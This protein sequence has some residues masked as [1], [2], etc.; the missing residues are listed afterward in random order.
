MALDPSERLC[1]VVLHDDR[2]SQDDVL[3]STDILPEGKI[4]ILKAK[5]AM[6]IHVLSTKRAGASR[7]ISLHVT[8]GERFLY[9]NRMSATLTI[10]NDTHEAT[11]NHV[12]FFF[13]DICLSRAD[14]WQ[15]TR[16]MDGGIIYRDQEIKFLGSDTAIART[17][18]INGQESDSAFVRQP[19]TKPI[20]RSGSARFVLLIQVSRE[21]LE[22]WINGHLMYESLIEGFLTELFKRWETS[23]MRHHFSVILFGKGVNSTGSSDANGQESYG[24]GD[25]FH[26]ICEDVPGSDWCTVVQRLKQAFHSSRLPRQVSLAR[27]GNLLEAIYTAALDVVNDSMDPHLSNTGLSIIAITAG[28]G[29]FDSDHSLLKET[30]NLL[31]GNSIGVDIVA[32]SPKP[33]H[34]VPL[35]K[36]QIKQNVEY[37]LPHWADVSYWQES[38]QG[39]RWLF[40]E[41]DEILDVSIAPLIMTPRS[42]PVTSSTGL[43]TAFDSA[44]FF[45]EDSTLIA[46]ETGIQDEFAPETLK[47]L[48][49]DIKKSN[50]VSY[51]RPTS[52]GSARSTVSKTSSTFT[53]P[54]KES[55]VHLLLKP[56]RKISLGPRGMAPVSGVASTTISTEYASHG[57]EATSTIF[58]PNEASSGLAKQIR[59]SLARK[60]SQQSL[61]SQSGNEPSRSTRPININGGSIPSVHEFSHANKELITEPGGENFTPADPPPDQLSKTPKPF[62]SRT[63][64]PE[65]EAKELAQQA[66]TPWLTLINPCNPKRDNMRIASQYRKWHHVFPKAIDSG[67]FKWDSMG[68]PASLPLSTDFAPT[69]RELDKHYEHKVRRLILSGLTDSPEESA[70]LIHKLISLRLSRGFQLV[71]KSS[72]ANTNSLRTLQGPILLSVGTLYHEIEI[73]SNL[74]L[75]VIEY[76][77]KTH[78]GLV[79]DTADGVKRK[80]TPRLGASSTSIDVQRGLKN[81]DWAAL[82]QALVNDTTNMPIDGASQMRFVLLPV[83][84]ASRTDAGSNTIRSRDLSEEEK[85]IDGIQKLTQLWQRHRLVTSEDKSHQASLAKPTALKS[86]SDRDPNPLAIEYQ[87]R[88][89]SA[90]LNTQDTSL[91]GHLADTEA[92]IPL[93]AESEMYHS[94][95]FDIVKL[96]KQM[97]EPPPLG[98]E[99][100]DRRWLARLH[101]KC[102]RGDEMTNWLLGVFK[103]ITTREEA[104][105]MGNELMNRGIFTHV[106]HKHEFRDGN[107]FYQIAAIHRTTEYPDNGGF[108]MKGLGRSVPVTPMSESRGSPLSRPMLLDPDSSSR[109]TPL[110][111]PTERKQIALSQ[112]LQYNVDPSYK[113]IRPEIINLH[114]D[115]IHN[116]ENCYHIYLDW[117]VTTPKLIREA[118][119][120]WSS[121]AESHGMKLVQV[122]IAE[123]SKQYLTHPFD[124]PQHVRLVSKP[125]DRAPVTPYLSAHSAMSRNIEDPAHYHKAILRKAGFVLDLES[126]SSFSSKLDITYSWGKPDYEMTQFIHKSGLVL[127]QISNDPDHDFLVLPNRLTLLRS[128]LSGKQSDIISADDVIKG[129]KLFCR[130]EKGLRMVYDEAR[131][132]KAPAPSPFTSAALSAGSD[133]DVPPMLLPPHVLHRVQTSDT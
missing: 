44:Q 108:F 57:R 101:Y 113:S 40:G 127:A 5:N 112:M 103:N 25:F 115:R 104:V 9:E 114:F 107:Y 33:L 45:E 29:Y 35:F 11:A 18:Y 76:I 124:K 26:N 116:P 20:F 42:I 15:M 77:P 110:L 46:E 56:G 62:A 68:A 8:L 71:A 80:Y 31:L 65:V 93:F 83:D 121:L 91:T 100:R 63:S 43:M 17:I 51:D 47:V 85:R 1:T 37:A 102:F 36:Y 130:D 109:G 90:V 52:D 19:I 95:N 129:F 34:P 28:T 78:D 111:L 132:R 60:S 72:K 30:T 41:A 7:E 117:L 84:I 86:V 13:R 89:T 120:R 75:Q 3:C 14:M 119:N 4:G 59:Q 69:P 58:T 67:A 23:K 133:V 126:A 118:L 32:L 21:M 16:S 106:R 6:P 98:V 122:P 22:R 64:L 97:Q 99:V 125:P 48:N 79:P 2:V 50:V 105:E 73:V 39:C 54:K 74:E 94:S 27:H 49:M 53:K 70:G 123:A 92:P 24:E 96:V 82:D 66:L 10:V 88:D 131:K 81:L 87:T 55:S 128:S 38:D 12:E 61:V